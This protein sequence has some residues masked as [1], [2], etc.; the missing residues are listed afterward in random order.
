M[1]DV[2]GRLEPFY[3]ESQSIYDMS[4]DFFALFLGPTWATPARTSNATT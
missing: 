3:E 2:D 1:S 4:N